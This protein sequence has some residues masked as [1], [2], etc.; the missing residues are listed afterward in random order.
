MGGRITSGKG[1]NLPDTRLRCPS[2]TEKD[3]EDLDWAI[4]QGLD[5]VAISFVRTPDDVAQVRDRIVR[6]GSPLLPVA[7]IEKPEALEHLDEIIDLSAAIMV[8]RGDLGV[9][10]D[11]ARVPIIQK[12]I[13]RRC[14]LA[15]KPVIIATQMLQSM[16]ENPFPTRA[17][18]SDVANA[19]YDR[20]DAVMLSAE[21]AVGRFPA[22]TVATMHHIADT[23]ERYIDEAGWEE[24]VAPHF[25]LRELSAVA[26]GAATVAHELEASLLVVWSHG[27][28]TARLLSKCRPQI[29]VVGISRDPAICRQMGMHYGVLPVRMDQPA[30]HDEMLMSVDR[31]VREN[32]WAEVGDLI[33]V[34]VG[35]RLDDPGATSRLLMRRVAD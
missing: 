14:Q 4:G 32:G 16:V 35:T 13:A 23:A 18:V 2:L 25:S 11:L 12:D 20:C 29:P 10:M 7:K 27:G 30:D 5:Y 31:C 3:F 24:G 15:G 28:T 34:V 19:I 9:E 33:V 22:K 17:E 21:S 8:A 1:I 26:H 6:A